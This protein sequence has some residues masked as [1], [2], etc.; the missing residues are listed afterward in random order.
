MIENNPKIIGWDKVILLETDTNS[1]AR[2]K[3][4]VILSEK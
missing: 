4:N 1:V 3:R 2:I